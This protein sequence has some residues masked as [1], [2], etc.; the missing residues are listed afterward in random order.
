MTPVTSCK[1]SGELIT[2]SD[3][4]I[5]N[6]LELYPN[7]TA[8]ELFIRMDATPKQTIVKI[9]DALGQLLIA[10]EF[11]DVRGS[12]IALPA[13]GISGNQLLFVTVEADGKI[14]DMK[15]VMLKD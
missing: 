15:H 13:T 3:P 14:F 6:T 10:S 5:V 8:E 1:H 11:S 12:R 4:G 2:G 9:Y 7:P